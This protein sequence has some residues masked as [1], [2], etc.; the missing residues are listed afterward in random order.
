MSS[1]WFLFYA[2]DTELIVTFPPS[3][4]PVSAH[5]DT[6]AR[7]LVIDSSSSAEAKSQLDGAGVYPLRCI[8][9]SRSPW[10][11]LRL[12]YLTLHTTSGEA[13]TANCPSVPILLA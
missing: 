11:I 8:I 1:H 5:I 4:A 3:E 10:T 2:D 9:L 12:H 7:H 6:V 13:S